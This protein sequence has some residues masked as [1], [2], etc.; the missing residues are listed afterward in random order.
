M[1][2]SRAYVLLLWF[3]PLLILRIIKTPKTCRPWITRCC[4]PEDSTLHNHRC[5]DLEL[6]M[7]LALPQSEIHLITGTK[8]QFPH[9]ECN[10]T[11][12]NTWLCVTIRENKI[13]RP[14]ITVFFFFTFSIVRYSRDYKTRRFW[15]WICFLPQVKGKTPT[16]LGPLERANFNHWVTSQCWTQCWRVEKRLDP[17]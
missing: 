15:N 17:S 2:L 12:I 3:L 1:Q 9:S 11:D 13:K 14:T 4:N 7:N 16:H 5:E 10:K 8:Y 6:S